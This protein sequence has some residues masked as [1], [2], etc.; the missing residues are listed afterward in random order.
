MRKTMIHIIWKRNFFV[1]IF[2]VCILLSGCNSKMEFEKSQDEFSTTYKNDHIEI[3]VAN[4]VENGEEIFQS[5]ER[6]LNIINNFEAIEKLSIRV[7]NK[8]LKGNDKS[9]VQCNAK[10]V[11]TPQFKQLLIANA[12]DLYDNWKAVGIYGNLFADDMNT[13]ADFASYY[14]NHDFSLFGAHFFPDFSSEEEIQNL[15]H[16]STS[17][18]KY[19]L[20]NGQKEKLLNEE[21]SIED[22]KPW[23]EQNHIDLTYLENL[24]NHINEIKVRDSSAIEKLYLET[25]QDINGFSI[26]VASIDD[27]FNTATKLEQIIVQF[28]KDIENNLQVIQAQAPNFYKEYEKALTN[29][30]KI[31]YIFNADEIL[32]KNMDDTGLVYL[33]SIPFQMVEYNHSLFMNSFRYNGFAVNRPRWY[34]EGV[35]GYLGMIYSPGLGKEMFQQWITSSEEYNTISYKVIKMNFE[36]LDELPRNQADKEKLLHIY[37][38]ASYLKDMKPVFLPNNTVD[39]SAE[40]SN[41]NGM[42]TPNNL[43]FFVNFSFTTYMIQQYGLEKM[44]YMQMQDFNTMSFEK[45]FGKSY[46][47]LESDWKQYL[48]D[49][50]KSGELLVYGEEGQS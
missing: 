30:P 14:Q 5:I 25:R 26:Q 2:L 46:E 40:S 1:M 43:N 3:K 38:G 41:Q 31:Q 11:K 20:D 29:V 35:D 10:F 8:F 34:L 23:A 44:L 32:N 19:L 9:G 45:Y 17:L 47:Q 22:I 18:V 33:R 24:Y 37:W 48:I 27:Q 6:D 13:N 21:I 7:D 42:H 15:T 28:D 12:Y 50:I 16:A 4:N 49:N 36:N 39:G